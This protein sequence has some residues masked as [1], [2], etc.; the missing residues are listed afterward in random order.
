LKTDVELALRRK[1]K[2]NQSLYSVD[3][4]ERIIAAESLSNQQ[5]MQL[6]QAYRPSSVKDY[7]AANAWVVVVGPSG[8]AKKKEKAGEQLS[9][10]A[11]PTRPKHLVLGEVHEAFERHS[12]EKSGF[13][14]NLFDVLEV[15]FRKRTSVDCESLNYLKAVLTTNLS[16]KQVGDEA[17]LADDE[18]EAGI[19]HFLELLRLCK[20]RVVAALTVRVY[21]LLAAYID[22]PEI[23][24]RLTLDDQHII[25]NRD[26][27]Y[28][29][30]SCWMH[31]QGVGRILLV[32]FPHPSR[33]PLFGGR[34]VSSVGAYLGR[35]FREALK[36]AGLESTPLLAD[37]LGELDLNVREESDILVPV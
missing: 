18:L 24:A 34:Y 29:P 7:G 14:R 23:G 12:H 5:K 21:K 28:K 33:A 19:P 1:S 22:Q 13:W 20:P 8:G 31:V 36:P 11:P 35:R 37:S 26:N 3:S 4:A 9:L 10:L 27:V 25:K 2:M 17:E 6:L 32:R 16:P 30:R 15:G